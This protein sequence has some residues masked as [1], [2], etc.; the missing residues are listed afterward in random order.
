MGD[1]IGYARVS[2]T[3]QQSDLQATHSPPR[4]AF[5]SSSTRHPASRPRGPSSGD[6]SIISD[7][8]TRSWS[9]VWI[10]WAVTET[11]DRRDE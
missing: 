5:G 10:G 9:G 8:V 3:D 11:F 6:A 1:L 7:Q 2:T 4:G